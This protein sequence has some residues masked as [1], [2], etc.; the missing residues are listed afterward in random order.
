MESWIGK[1]FSDEER[2][3]GFDTVNLIGSNC[4]LN[5]IHNESD[6]KTYANISA[7]TSVPKG[8]PMIQP[9][10]KRSVPEWI[11]KVRAKAIKNDD[12]LPET[13]DD[14]IPYQ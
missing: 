14:D 12:A 1:V 3:T 2:K 11:D 5:I 6:G 4:F 10:T 13:M 8:I 9:E 7:I